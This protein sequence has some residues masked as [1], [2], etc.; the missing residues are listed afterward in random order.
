VPPLLAN[1]QGEVD[2]Q[3]HSQ[4]RTQQY[5]Q[6]R[7]HKG[8]HLSFETNLECEVKGN[9]RYRT[10]E[11]RSAQL[12]NKKLMHRYP[13]ERIAGHTSIRRCQT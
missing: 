11:Q 4:H 3:L 10:I 6:L 7:A 1:A 9:S 2:G 12:A 13:P 5:L 8:R